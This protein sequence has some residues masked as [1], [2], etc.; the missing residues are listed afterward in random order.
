MA[1]KDLKRSIPSVQP[2]RRRI[3]PHLRLR[4]YE[5]LFHLNRGFTLTLINLD[6]LAGLGIIPA[7]YLRPY[8]VMA[9]ELRAL[10]NTKLLAGLES[11]E[12]R[13]ALRYQ[14]MRLKWER[15]SKE[16]PAKKRR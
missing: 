16:P 6:R 9:E 14:N 15:P 12:S 2:K 1:E 8:R 7:G 3:N 10:T 4:A 5:T 13:E 11:Q